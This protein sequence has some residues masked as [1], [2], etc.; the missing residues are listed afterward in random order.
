MNEDI[1]TE[2]ENETQTSSNSKSSD[3]NLKDQQHNLKALPE[4]GQNTA[5]T[6]SFGALFAAIGSLLLFGRKKK[7]EENK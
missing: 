1:V 2:S 4:T 7:R 6:T 3:N 5:N